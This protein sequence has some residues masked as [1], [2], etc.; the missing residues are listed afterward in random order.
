MVA[1][2][3]LDA[4]PQELLSHDTDQFL[5]VYPAEDPKSWPQWLVDKQKVKVR[6]QEQ[7]QAQNQ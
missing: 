5:R 3:I 1:G 7:S 2:K 4:G 6:R